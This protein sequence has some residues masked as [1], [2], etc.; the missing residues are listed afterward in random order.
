MPD[1][2]TFT[3]A[4]AVQYARRHA[5][6]AEPDRLVNAT[7][8]GDGNL[9]LVF[10]ILDKEGV[11]RVIVKQA[12]PYVRCVGESWPL[13]LDRARIEAQTLLVHGEFCQRHTARVLHHDEGLAVMIQEDLSQYIIWRQALLK[14]VHYPEAPRQLGV[15]LAE[16]LFHTSDFYL[17]AQFKKAQVARFTN[18]EMCQITEDLFFTDPYGANERNHYESALAT[19]VAAIHGDR[20]LKLA[21]AGLKHRF[22]TQAQAL[23]HGDIH[24]GSIF[25]DE[26]RLKVIDAEFGFFGPMGFDLGT[27][28]GNL[29]LNYCGL[30]GLLPLRAAVDAREQR[31]H[32]VRDLWVSF[33]ERFQALAAADSRDIMLA[34]PGYALQFLQQVWVDALG[35]CGTELIRRTIGFAHVADLD[36]I[37]DAVMG[38]ACRRNA[39]SLGKTLILAASHIPDADALIA[40]VRQN[41]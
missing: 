29:L 25:V 21:V 26:G 34:E 19:D 17:A 14:G 1:Y 24:S 6:L 5:G 8:V 7:E 12:L 30:P 15:Y 28:I 36:S 41:G 3:A 35:Y 9:N 13:T 37:N 20:A 16:T 27:A 11:S 40:R 10:K 18:P 33:A 23:L 4:E 31:L 39:L 2:H 32:D 38:L 22:L